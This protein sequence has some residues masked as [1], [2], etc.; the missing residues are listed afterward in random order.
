MY[1]DFHNTDYTVNSRRSIL[2]A[3]RIQVC[4]TGRYAQ[5][6]KRLISICAN[7]DRDRVNL[8]VCL[9]FKGTLK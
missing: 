1:I 2:T 9:V 7:E 8:I 5:S 4:F 3:F 6:A